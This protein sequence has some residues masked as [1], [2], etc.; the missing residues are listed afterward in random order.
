MYGGKVSVNPSSKK[1]NEDYL[2]YVS[3]TMNNGEDVHIGIIADGMGGHTSGDAASYYAVHFILKWWKRILWEHDSVDAFF[4]DCQASIIDVFYEINDNLIELGRLENKKIGTTL[5]VI[6]FV[7]NDYYVCHIG[8]TRIY[9]YRE[10]VLEREEKPT[11]DTIDL[12]E[13]KS[14]LQLTEDHSWA[15]EQIKNG[16][17]EP[18]AANN[19]EKSHYLTQCLGVK[20]GIKPFTASGS[21]TSADYFLLTSDG[22][23]NL[24][25]D[26]WIRDQ[27]CNKLEEGAS[28]Q[29]I[30]DYFYK[31]AKTSH[32]RDDVSILTVNISER[33]GE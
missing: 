18:E 7:G 11:D 16:K 21:F 9:R 5:S 19:H 29:E 27:W 22:F 26:N 25:S 32:F 20:G 33:T 23:H 30:C 24:F 17:M 10:S 31:L 13:E 14:L 28:M 12:D 2:T 6:L 1:V 15:S 3:D 8:D 4:K